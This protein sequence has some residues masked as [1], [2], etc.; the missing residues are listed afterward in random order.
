VCASHPVRCVAVH[1][2]SSSLPT[3]NPLSVGVRFVGPP[4]KISNA[5]DDAIASGSVVASVPDAIQG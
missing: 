5:E 4:E 3:S 1:A 2:F